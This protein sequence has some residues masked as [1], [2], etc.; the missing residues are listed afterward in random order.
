MSATVGNNC[1]P[2]ALIGYSRA[3]LVTTLRH[4]N[5]AFH[6]ATPL[7]QALLRGNEKGNSP[8]FAADRFQR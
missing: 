6:V 4:R 5:M 3:G 8:L 1:A 7:G 2:G